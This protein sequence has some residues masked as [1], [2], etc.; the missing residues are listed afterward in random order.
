M[1]SQHIELPFTSEMFAKFK[2]ITGVTILIF[3]PDTSLKTNIW[4]HLPFHTFSF[5]VYYF[6]LCSHYDE[7]H[8]TRKPSVE[9]SS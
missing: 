2:P 5:H 3:C 6:P 7:R 8:L 1:F 9:T 4:F